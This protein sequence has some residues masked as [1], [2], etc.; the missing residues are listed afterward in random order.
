[1]ISSS[2]KV[3]PLLHLWRARVELPPVTGLTFGGFGGGLVLSFRYLSAKIIL[4]FPFYGSGNFGL[5]E[6][7]VFTVSVHFALALK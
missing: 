1:M 7:A 2:A 3:L 6:I 4:R 5:T